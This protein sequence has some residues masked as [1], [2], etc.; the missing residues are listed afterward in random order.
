MLGTCAGLAPF[1]PL[2]DGVPSSLFPSALPTAAAQGIPVPT[3]PDDP[4]VRSQWDNPALRSD[5]RQSTVRM[6]ILELPSSLDAPG[7]PMRFHV[8]LRNEGSQSIDHLTLLLRRA[9]KQQSLAQTRQILAL[10]GAAYPEGNARINLNANLQPGATHEVSVEVPTHPDNPGALPLN[11]PG[12]YPIFVALEGSTPHNGATQL[13][14]QRFLLTVHGEVTRPE[15]DGSQDAESRE[16][17]SL[18]TSEQENPAAHE[19]PDGRDTPLSAERE[20]TDLSLILPLSSQVDI[21]PGETGEAPGRTPLLLSSERLAEELSTGGRLHELLQTY[22]QHLLPGSESSQGDDATPTTHENSPNTESSAP[23]AAPS[24]LRDS[25]CL[26]L[27]PSLVETVSRMAEGYEV[28]G[29]RPEIQTSGQRLRN[30]WGT[31]NAH[32]STTPGRGA[33]AAQRWLADLKELAKETCVVTLPW[34]T[35]DLDAV[36]ATNNS[37][38][39]REAL[40]RGPKVLENILGVTPMENVVIPESGYVSPPTI[41]ALGWAASTSDIESDFE[42]SS[43]ATPEGDNPDPET[44]LNEDQTPPTTALQPPSP[45]ADNPVTVLLANNTV[46]DPESK[47]RFTQLAPG[48]RA[49]SYQASLAATL[50]S[51]GPHPQVLGY[52]NP[53]T[54]FDAALDSLAAR[55]AT[56][57]SALQLAVDEQSAQPGLTQPLLVMPPSELSASTAQSILS[58]AHSL[59]DRHNARPMGLRLYLHPNEEQ[60]H[61][62]AQAP[63]STD[64]FPGIENTGS[65]YDDPGIMSDT[66]VLQA[67]REAAFTDDLT[68]LLTNDPTIALTRYTFS[69]PLRHELLRSLGASGRQSLSAYQD[70]VNFTA[71]HLRQNRERLLALGRAV[72]LIPPG[73]VY[74]RTSNS[75]PLMVVA[76]NRLPLPVDAAVQYHAPEDVTI[77]TP[78]KIRI[79]ASGSITVQLTPDIPRDHDQTHMQLWLSTRDGAAIS[80]PVD[81]TVQDRAGM[82]STSGLAFI[83]VIGLSLVLVFRVGRHRQR[84]REHH[85]SSRAAQSRPRPPRSRQNGSRE[86][87]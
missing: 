41:R 37:W 71:E 48:I 20:P 30:S 14:S 29:S 49:V 69:N 68:R 23:S 70:A 56:A 53:D 22:R 27:D 64:N 76:E 12:V 7:T 85:P 78:E 66:E 59:F 62:L 52:S 4:A 61:A 67:R 47:E 44:T 51:T 60:S 36:A 73:G 87:H 34:A 31:R 86:S 2:A 28:G 6:E 82:F 10:N 83:A 15:K 13:T 72:T 16:T 40:G 9:E 54:R 18:D 63:A 45:S 84:A 55:D 39:M 24:P 19:D 3:Y 43:G 32:A 79:P 65:P 17:S 38:L 42:Q 11:E 81:L 50:H 58:S 5:D 77:H 46:W 25:A 21:V 35:T 75:S 8:K 26:A 1:G 57:S 33:E 74:T 80:T